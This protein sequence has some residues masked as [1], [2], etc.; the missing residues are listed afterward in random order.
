MFVYNDLFVYQIRKQEWLKVSVPNAPPPRSA[1]QAVVVSQQNG[2]MWLFGGEFSSH[3]QAQFYHYKDLWVLHLKEKRW[4]QVKAP[5]GPSARSGHRM[6]ALKKQILVFGGFHDNTRDYKYFNDVYSFN[7]ETYTWSLLKPSGTGPSPRSGCVFLPVSDTGRAVVY[8]GY[9]KE[10][11]KRDVD[12]GTTHTDMFVLAPEKKRDGVPDHEQRW[13]WQSVKQSGL[14]PSAR[15]GMTGVLG[16]NNKAYLFGGVYDEEDEDEFLEGAFFNELWMLDLERLKWFSV[17]L[18]DLKQNTG[19]RKKRRR[20]KKEDNGDENEDSED[21]EEEEEEEDDE[22]DDEDDEMEV[23][24]QGVENLD[25]QTPGAQA[26][27]SVF[28]VTMAAPS[29]S[30]ANT[31]NDAS[32]DCAMEVDSFWPSRRMNTALAVKS[33]QLYM[34]GGVFE[35]GDRQLT[36]SDMYSLDV[37]R[38]NAWNVLAA[39]DPRLQEWHD[40][41]SDDDDG[42]DGEGATASGGKEDEDSDED[43]DES[44]EITFDDAPSRREG[45]GI[46]DYF[47]RS[48]EYWMSKARE[49]FE[50]DGEV[51]SDRRLLRFAKEVCEEACGK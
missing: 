16:T 36:L 25:I 51:I 45:E 2:Q 47:E 40:S 28:K 43:S 8:G 37:Q 38:P 19:D 17:Q 24:Q 42:K 22:E 50:E 27:E 7:L 1:H 48:K 3:S 20:K 49:I 33:G 4:E 6:M 44:M 11:V 32:S 39:E 12:K 30:N 10:R 35:E 21:G 13:K 9:S 34:Y 41:D 5:G 14:K 23:T 31:G 26:E 29:S 18:K 46:G 15:S